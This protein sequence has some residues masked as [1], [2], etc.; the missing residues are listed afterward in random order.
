MD[1]AKVMESLK[2]P[3]INSDEI[4]GNDFLEMLN[5]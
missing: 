4:L 2:L 1:D 5:K 3:V